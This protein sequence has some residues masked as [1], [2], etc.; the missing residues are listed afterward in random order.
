ML[1]A[2][3]LRGLCSRGDTIGN[4]VIFCPSVFCTAYRTAHPGGLAVAI[5]IGH[6]QRGPIGA[7]VLS[8]P[9]NSKSPNRCRRA[10]TLACFTSWPPPAT[11]GTTHHDNDR[12]RGTDDSGGPRLTATPLTTRGGT[13]SHGEIS[14]HVASQARRQL[15]GS[16]VKS[17]ADEGDMGAADQ[18]ALPP[19][20]RS[21]R[22]HTVPLARH[23]RL[24]V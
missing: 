8:V 4:W 17:A 19:T 10:P 12:H 15:E 11:T 14:R 7:S 13:E 23:P 9:L 16:T 6:R 22:Q 18:E 5:C 2:G 24:C 1:R 3:T 21:C 20:H